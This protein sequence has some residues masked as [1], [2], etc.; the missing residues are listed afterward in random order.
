MTR[1][2]MY[3]GQ[4]PVDLP[5]V[6]QKEALYCAVGRCATRLKDLI[7]FGQ[8]LEHTLIAEAQESNSR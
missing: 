4:R 6:V 2:Y 3:L 8:W 7:P 5:G 1:S